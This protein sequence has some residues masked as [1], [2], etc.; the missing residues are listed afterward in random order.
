MTKAT[1]AVTLWAPRLAAMDKVLNYLMIALNV[2]LIGF[3][4]VKSLVSPPTCTMTAS[5]CIP[6][7]KSSA[8]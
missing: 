4:L 1:A 8:G 6:I 7:L 5:G 2:I 3:L